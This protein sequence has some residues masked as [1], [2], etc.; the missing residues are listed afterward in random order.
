VVNPGAAEKR[1][2][3]PLSDGTI[4]RRGDILRLETG[5]GGGWGHP[6]DR[7]A[8]DVLADVLGGFVTVEAAARDYGVAIAAGRVDA[9]RTAALREARGETR[10]F[11]RK[12][13]TNAVA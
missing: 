8:E 4:L 3:P 10:L 9:T 11:H 13:Y 1:V 12:G 5:G 2:L 6:F 7:P